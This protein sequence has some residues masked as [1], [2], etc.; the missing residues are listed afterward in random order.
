MFIV[1]KEKNGEDYYYL[2]KSERDGEKVIAKDIA[3]LGKNKKEAEK[4]LLKLRRI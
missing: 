4:K 2:R 1:K 3:Y